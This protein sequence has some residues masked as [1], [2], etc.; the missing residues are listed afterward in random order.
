MRQAR[1]GLATIFML[2]IASS[3]RGQSLTDE[4][5][6][7]ALRAGEGRRVAQLAASCVATVGFKQSFTARVEPGGIRRTGAFSVVMATNVGRIAALAADAKR[8]YQPF[9]VESVS[10]EL[11]SRRV[12]ISVEPKEPVSNGNV[13]SVAPTVDHVVLQARG[14]GE[15][16]LQPVRVDTEAMEWFSVYASGRLE[17]NRVVAVFEGAD[18]GELQAGDLEVVVITPNGERRCVIDAKT[19]SRLLESP[20]V[21]R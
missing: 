3:G 15:R 17:G 10:E 12:Y 19:R 2:M 5:V 6:A 21:D 4:E 20:I 14:R 9:S 18:V 7:A 11:R 13:L 16:T 1:A 8:L